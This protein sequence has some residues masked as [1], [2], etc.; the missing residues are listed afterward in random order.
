MKY[1]HETMPLAR[2]IWIMGAD[3]L[4]QFRRWK[5]YQ[6]IIDLLPI[7]VIDRPGYSYTALS[8]GRQLL[9]FRLSPRRF[10]AG[11]LGGAKKPPAWCFIAGRRHHASA[12]ALRHADRTGNRA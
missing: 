12:T 1:L 4:V 5:R 3:N 11:A 6:E 8:K 9:T 2:L 7:A 10:A